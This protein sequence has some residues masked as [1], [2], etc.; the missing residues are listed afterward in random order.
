MSDDG[1]FFYTPGSGGHLRNPI[2]GGTNPFTGPFT[3]QGLSDGPLHLNQDQTI[4]QHHEIRGGPLSGH[5]VDVV[6]ADASQPDLVT[7]S[8]PSGA[9]AQV[10]DWAPDGSQVTTVFDPTNAFIWDQRTFAFGANDN[11]IGIATDY[12]SA[13]DGWLLDHEFTAA[14]LA[15]FDAA[16]AIDLSAAFERSV[17]RGIEA[18]GSAPSPLSFETSFSSAYDF[19]ASTFTVE[20]NGFVHVRDAGAGFDVTGWIGGGS[21]GVDAV[22][23]SFRFPTNIFDVVFSILGS[24]FSPII[25]DLDGDGVEVTPRSDSTDYFDVDGD[26]FLEQTAWAG[27]G[28]ALLMV[29]DGGNAVSLNEVSFARR[30]ADPNDTDLEALAAE[31]DTNRDGRLSSGDARWGDFWVLR[32]ST[33]QR[34]TISSWGITSISLTSDHQAVLLPDGSRIHGF[35]S[36]TMNGQTRALADVALSFNPDGFRRQVTHFQSFSEIRYEVQNGPDRVY[37]DYTT[38]PTRLVA[39]VA[40]P[41]AGYIG[42]PFND[43]IAAGSSLHVTISGGGGPDEIFGGEGN[44]VLDGGLGQGDVIDGGGGDDTIYFELS[45]VVDGGSGHDT[46]ILASNQELNN[47][48]LENL[49]LESLIANSG[50]DVIYATPDRSAY[51]DGRAGHDSLVGSSRGDVLVGGTGNDALLGQGGDDLLNGGGDHDTLDGGDGQDVI[52]GGEGND[53]LRGQS[54]DDTLDGGTGADSMTGSFGSDTY[55][56]DEA[57]DVVTEN[58]GEGNDTV[59]ASIAFYAL[60]GSGVEN[61]IGS[62]AEQRLEG[63]RLANTITG[64]GGNDVFGFAPGSGSDVITD[65]AAGVGLGDRV[66]LTAFPNA[67]PGLAGI[68]SES[69]GNTVLNFGNGDVLTLQNVRQAALHV[70]DFIFAAGSGGGDVNGDSDILWLN[71]DGS[72]LTWE[73]QDGQHLSHYHHGTVSTAWQIRGT[74]DF[75]GDGDGDILWHNSNGSVLTWEMEDGQHYSHRDHGQASTGWQIRGTGDFDGDGDDDILW[76]NTDGLVVTWVM[77]DGVRHANPAHAQVPTS[78][79]IRGTGDFDGDGDD[80]IVWQNTDGT[81]VT[82]AMED[83]VRHANPAHGQVATNWQITGTGDFDGDGDDDILWRQ[84]NAEGLVT[85]NMQNG[86]RAS[87]TSHAEVSTAWQIRGIGDFDADGD[88]DI[89]WQHSDTTVLTWEMQNGQHVD[90]SS[91]GQVSANW[92]I[93]GTGDFDLI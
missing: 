31:F 68:I 5:G 60:P 62:V 26:N 90:H 66:D 17:Y 80:D 22:G 58:G 23:L 73:M 12:T 28:D 41:Y 35:G 53:T 15:Q 33:G 1:R 69:G 30:T 88:S 40:G 83:G 25:L 42:S 50:N 79:Q 34:N 11:P 84:T 91:H 43:W 81:V 85:W 59:R 89:L 32:Q 9:P 24:L 67:R 4:E 57:G 77:E 55:M 8:D 76:R 86:V 65:F 39:S 93:R 18:E 52:F 36:F 29:E 64:G 37:L 7:I 63:N 92:Q 16:A 72:V 21:N 74:G 82:W 47:F 56:V 48:R 13:F 14:E 38:N 27:P 54:G 61:L 87:N 45:D 71:T 78:W 20:P 3:P 70:D 75:D 2:S 6:Y 51:I 46:G 10:Q 44:D 49:D 19:R